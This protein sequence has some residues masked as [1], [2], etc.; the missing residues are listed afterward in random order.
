MREGAAAPSHKTKQ[1]IGIICASVECFCVF[2]DNWNFN[3]SNPCLYAGG[4]YNQNL[5][6]GAFYVNYT[7][8]S[9]ANAN[10]GC[11]HLAYLG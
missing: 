11:R 5:N 2:P 4:Y 6:Y 7:N 1:R 8:A 10:I 3:A 9:N